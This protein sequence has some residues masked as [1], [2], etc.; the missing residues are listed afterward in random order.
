MEAMLQ[1]AIR[2][3]RQAGELIR[4]AAHDVAAL[5]VR[6][7]RRN[8]FVSEVDTAAEAVIL[9]VL[10]G[11]Y[12]AHQFLAEES[13]ASGEAGRASGHQ[14][15]VDPLD[16]TTNFLHGVP[17]YAVSIALRREGALALAAV[18]DPLK[19]ELFT[20][21]RGGGA[22]LNG[23]PISVS[24]PR[25]LNECLVA[26]GIPFRNPASLDQYLAML[27][28]LSHKTAGVR[29]FGA[30]ALDLAWVACG[31]FDGFWELDLMAW[32]M[33]AGA[34]LISEAG[35]QVG[36]LDGG[37]GYLER[38]SLLAGNA[39]VYA[40]LVELARTTRGPGT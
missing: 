39:T 14:W 31:R 4:R 23:R 10:R 30:A 17:Q 33:A 1:T 15:I 5:E 8:D 26:T 20:A 22:F 35:G 19:D 32:D 37:P 7:K 24:T 34:L 21:T 3:A 9:A 29:R 16:G 40:Y 27:R 38:C 36:D 25:P 18:Y 12:P 6:S 11:A 13:G 2:A 28:D